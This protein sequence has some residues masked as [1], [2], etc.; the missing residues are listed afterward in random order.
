MMATKALFFCSLLTSATASVNSAWSRVNP[1]QKVIT[2]I[3]ELEGKILKEGEAEQKA[4]EE[5]FEWCDDAAKNKQFEL[6]TATSA[7]NKLEATIAKAKSDTELATDKIA[8]QAAAIAQNEADLKAA[9]EIREKE[10][11]D[12]AASES[13]LVDAVDTLERAIG[14]IEKSMKGSS[15]LQK[16]LDNANVETL[17]KTLNMVIDSASFTGHDKQTL[18]TLMQN[19]QNSDEDDGIGEFGAPAP[20]AYKSHSGGIV[21]VLGDMKDKAEGELA[22]ARKA[23]MNAQHNYDMLKQSL[24]DEIKAA[25]HEKTEAETMKSEAESTQATAEGDLAVTIKD[26]DDINGA[27]KTVSTDCMTSASD[28]EVST[29]GRADEL[30]AL[31][32]AK[33][34]I[35]QSAAGAE[36]QAYSFFEI[37]S[38]TNSHLRSASDLR[39]FEVV[40]AVKRL[41]QE[42]HSAGLAQLASR[43]S[44]L[45]RYSAS[46]GEDP[47]AKVKELIT[48]M[49]AKL[50]KEA[51]SEASFKAYCDE[52]MAKTKAKKEELSADL[53]KLNS[54]LDTATS[55]SVGLK[56]DVKELQK[57][58]ANLVES[59]AE[60]DKARTDE[61]AAFE[62]A[63]TDLEAGING[64]R[65]AL[66][67]LR[68]F[69]QADAALLQGKNLGAFMQSSQNQPAKPA[70]HSKASG[71]G[72]SIIDM[73]EVIE[74]DFA[75]NLAQI[76]EEESAAQTAYDK[77]TQEN[78]VTKAQKEQD[79][80]YKTE[81]YTGLD[82]EVAELSSDR[83]TTESELDAVLEYD[84]KIKDQCIAKPETY[85][86]RKKR[87]E[88]EI[89]GLKEAL[90]ILE[91]QAFI[92]RKGRSMNLRAHGRL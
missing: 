17:M 54:K 61:K 79:V 66:D 84:T 68:D 87:R 80:K 2:L 43:L 83:E 11:A 78:K 90:S 69:Y 47:F 48:D 3:S 5:F 19:K 91:G 4:Y 39:N 41:A 24:D 55:R 38:L 8:E 31:A 32:T 76:E 34:I 45:Y 70:G 52:E 33:K 49:I 26:L 12:F 25:Q 42:Q 9:T 60:M 37:N 6:K 18:L 23:E 22:E 46:T 36:K 65:G 7:K 62:V 67:V 59:Q 72:G 28:H 57:E 77:L 15:L 75:K 81:E 50:M 21:D 58:L 73:L 13:E 89:A 86:E 10:H 85:E 30:K 51:E 82:K 27:L 74:S 29:Q 35:Q 53:R 40:N 16:N 14:V 56:E 1:I 20:D 44:A 63:K 88:A 71:A 92:Q 64:V